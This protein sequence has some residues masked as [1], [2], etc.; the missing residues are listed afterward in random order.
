M[1]LP[2]GSF[3]PENEESHFTAALLLQA[4][5]GSEGTDNAAVSEGN[6]VLK[7]LL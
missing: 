6:F 3:F 5:E 7:I 4:T 1:D 2:E